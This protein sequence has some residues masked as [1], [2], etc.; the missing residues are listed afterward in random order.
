MPD[1]LSITM[2]HNFQMGKVI[3]VAVDVQRATASGTKKELLPRQYL[4]AMYDALYEILIPKGMKKRKHL[5]ICVVLRVS[6]RS[7]SGVRSFLQ[8]GAWCGCSSKTR[9]WVGW[10]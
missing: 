4:L 10:N 8:R 7:W 2:K 3:P 6:A 1:N 5:L 9:H